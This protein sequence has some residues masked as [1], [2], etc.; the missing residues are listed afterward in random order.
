MQAVGLG[1]DVSRSGDKTAYYCRQHGHLS[2]PCACI[3]AYFKSQVRENRARQI[4]E[5]EDGGSKLLAA[6]RQGRSSR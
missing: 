4:R 1:W 6:I 5:N 3:D 2:E